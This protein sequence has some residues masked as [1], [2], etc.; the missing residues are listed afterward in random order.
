MLKILLDTDL[1]KQFRFCC[2]TS[3]E[4]DVDIIIE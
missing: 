3:H 2:P 4:S 1:N